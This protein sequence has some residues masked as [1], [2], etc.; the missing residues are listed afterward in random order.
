VAGA[1]GGCLVRLEDDHPEHDVRDVTFDRV[2]I[3]GPP[4]ATGRTYQAS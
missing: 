3:H 1:P 4:A 2:T